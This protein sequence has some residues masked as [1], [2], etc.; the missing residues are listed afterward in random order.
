[1]AEEIWELIG[2]IPLRGTPGI[3]VGPKVAVK[4]GLLSYLLLNK[5]CIVANA[6]AQV[7]LLAGWRAK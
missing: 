6:V 5:R 1:M 2:L 7:L 4:S 3:V